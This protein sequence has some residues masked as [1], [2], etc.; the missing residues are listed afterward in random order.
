PRPGRH[1]RQGIAGEAAGAGAR[2]LRAAVGRRG[3]PAEEGGTPG[4]QGAEAMSEPHDPN[5][6]SDV[7]SVPADSLDAGLAAGFGRQAARPRPGATD[8][9]PLLLSEPQGAPTHP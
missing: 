9:P 8:A 6:P 4:G 3:G 5:A 1:P 7:S 2:R